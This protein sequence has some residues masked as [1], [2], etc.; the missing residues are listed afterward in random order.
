MQEAQTEEKPGIVIDGW[1]D[2]DL[3]L[4][5]MRLTTAE[6]EA[7]AAPF[8]LQIA[9]LQDE[10]AAACRDRREYLSQLD[11]AVMTFIVGHKDEIPPGKKSIVLVHAEVGVRLGTARVVMAEDDKTMIPRLRE[12]GLT[13]CLNEKTEISKNE[14]KKLAPEQLEELGIAIEQSESPFYKLHESPLVVYPSGHARPAAA[15]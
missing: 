9:S 8:D 10:K 4:A 12:A 13:R 15:K 2:L 11:A 7:Q 3:H 14:I 6:I 1:P 5:A